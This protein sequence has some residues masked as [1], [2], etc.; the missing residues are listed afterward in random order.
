M[1][2]KQLNSNQFPQVYQWLGI[3][4]DKLGCV[5]A[6]IMPDPLL[7]MFSYN[8]DQLSFYYSKDPAKFWINGWCANTNPHVTLLFGLLQPA[9][10]FAPHIFQVMQ[11]WDMPTVEVED[12]GFFESPYE[13][14][15]YYCVVAHLKVT[16]ALLEGHQ[17]LEFLPHI[18]TF[19]GY[20]PHVSICY[21]KQDQG[22]RDN[23][24][25]ML[26]QALVGKELTVSPTLNLGGEKS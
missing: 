7:S 21:I 25:A 10:N 23:V 2:G 18:N 5:M 20:R 14:E 15:P 1:D 9:C 26:K 12:V 6:D 11:G 3:D 22:L 19:A 17:R 13:D 24:V 8:I 4:V 16:P